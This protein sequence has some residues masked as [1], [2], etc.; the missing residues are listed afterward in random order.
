[1]IRFL[2]NENT[3]NRE[4]VCLSN[5]I[6]VVSFMISIYLSGRVDFSNKK[7]FFGFIFTLIL[8]KQFKICPYPLEVI[9][10]LLQN[11]PSRSSLMNYFPCN[12]S[13]SE[14]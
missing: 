9:F 12:I 10:F 6:E 11:I 14:N 7:E 4:L 3:D 13:F 1:M 2:T 5:I 8:E